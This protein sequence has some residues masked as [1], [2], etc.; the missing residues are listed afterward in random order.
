MSTPSSDT[1]LTRRLEARLAE[2]GLQVAVERFEDALVLS[3]FVDSEEARWAAA[4]IVANAAPDLRI[5]N[6]LEVVSVLPTTTEAFSSDESSA[7]LAESAAAIEAG[8]GELEPDFTRRFV[9]DPDEVVDTDDA[10]GLDDIPQ[11]GEVYTPPIDPVVTT[12]AH[13]DPRVLGGFALDD[14]EDM[15]VEPSADGRL[16]DEALADAVRR[17]L[18]EDAATSDL[19]IYVAVRNRVAHLR[20]RVAD[21]DDADNAE[22]VAARVP[23]IDEVIEELDVEGI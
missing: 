17:E 21:L 19:S 22:S 6:Q 8:G 11:S 15:T 14:D 9:F 16:G 7:E 10:E 23:G 18:E 13:G 12:T 5:D 2:A 20:G 1:S 4:D 3:G